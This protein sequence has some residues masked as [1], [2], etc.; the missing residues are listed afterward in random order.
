MRTPRGGRA[1]L[2]SF[3]IPGPTSVDSGQ[4]LLNLANSQT[5]S[6]KHGSDL[7][8]DLPRDISEEDFEAICA[9]QGFTADEIDWVRPSLRSIITMIEGLTQVVQMPSIPPAEQ[10]K[11]VRRQIAYI[12][13][14]RSCRAVLDGGSGGLSRREV[15]A[16]F[17]HGL[18]PEVINGLPPAVTELARLREARFKSDDALTLLDQYIL[19]DAAAEYCYELRDY[20][21]RLEIEAL[22]QRIKRLKTDGAGK[23][24]SKGNI[25]RARL[26]DQL[27]E[28]YIALGRNPTP[29]KNG[30]FVNFVAGVL[31]AIG[32]PTEGVEDAVGKRLPAVKTQLLLPLKT[33]YALFHRAMLRSASPHERR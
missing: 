2:S 8:C 13:K 25:L 17:A 7:G 12:K 10:I 9:V 33:V 32:W 3:D 30:P 23:S 11:L 6:K 29:T 16:S 26:I 14:T 28:V 31:D 24:G 27:T 21:E 20:F 5:K 19:R 18:R 15:L 22:E 4:R 1:A